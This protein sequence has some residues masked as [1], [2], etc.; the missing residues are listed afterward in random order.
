[1]LKSTQ[2][3]PGALA[4]LVVTIV[5]CAP[6]PLPKMVGESEYIP[7]DKVDLASK[8]EN[9]DKAEKASPVTFNKHSLEN[10]PKFSA[11]LPKELEGLDREKAFSILKKE[12]AKNLTV[13]DR[14]QKGIIY[15]KN[16]EVNNAK[17]EFYAILD[18]QPDNKV[19][20]SMLRQ[21]E[22][23][24]KE[25]FTRFDS[26]RPKSYIVK[27]GDTFST[28]AAQFLNNALEF[29]VLAKYNY[30]SNSPKL[31]VGQ[32]IKIP[33]L[34]SR[35]DKKVKETKTKVKKK[36]EYSET[37][38]EYTLATKYYND[39]RYVSAIAVLEPRI[40][41]HKKD[42][43]SIDLL[44][45]TYTKYAN[46]LVNK[47]NLLEAHTILKKAVSI[48][49]GNKELT[50]RLAFVEKQREAER[51]YRNG[52]VALKKGS[53]DKA[54]DAFNNALLL[55]PDHKMAKKQ[56]VKMKSS[57]I[58]SLHKKAM[59]LY[60]NQ[61]LELAIS[62]WNKVLKINPDHELA[63]LYRARA[64]ELKERLDKLPN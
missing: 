3:W 39:G 44:V 18:R 32:E 52:L 6:I 47:A 5:S 21:I 57:V 56:I 48:Q 16:G 19:A 54:F 11:K 14:V 24:P 10:K 45:L 59:K 55:K 33:S 8:A 35:Q 36:R 7:A 23:T 46:H 37:K 22:N 30:F 28:L 50:N 26:S 40:Q 29:H 34:I 27:H 20:K 63:R 15:L 12:Q 4:V 31:V 62:N 41:A 64:V 9:Y 2:I 58:K 60:K 51:H 61:E 13:K 43:K 53:R 25:Y 1:M 38:I 17:I 49:P 42:Y